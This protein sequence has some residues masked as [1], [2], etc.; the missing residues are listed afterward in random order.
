MHVLYYEYVSTRKRLTGSNRPG[1]QGGCSELNGRGGG[2]RT[3]NPRFWRP[4]L[5]QL[6]Y[7]PMLRL[8]RRTTLATKLLENFRYHA[9]TDRTA[10]FA[11]GETDTIIHRNRLVK[12]DLDA[13]IVTRHAHF[14]LN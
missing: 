7:T 9:R 8:R 2:N 1:I 13:D 6:S 5:C 4:V 10:T 12:L 14:R 3:R 11:D